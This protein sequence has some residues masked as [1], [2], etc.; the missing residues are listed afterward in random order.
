MVNHGVK[1]RMVAPAGE[2]ARRFF[3][4][5]VSEHRAGDFAYFRAL[6]EEMQ[7]DGPGALL[8]YL[9]QR[10][11]SPDRVRNAPKTA[12]LLEQKL[13]SLGFKGPVAT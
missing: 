2:T 7:G 12:G 1:C 8:H 11:Y 13:L 4:P 9:Q 3:M 10:K 5:T 6:A